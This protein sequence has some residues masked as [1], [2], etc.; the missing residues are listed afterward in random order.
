[1]VEYLD[2]NNIKQNRI[3]INRIIINFTTAYGTR[4]LLLAYQENDQLDGS[5]EIIPVAEKIIHTP[6]K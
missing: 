4:A 3:I 1:M 6:K 2:G 5:S